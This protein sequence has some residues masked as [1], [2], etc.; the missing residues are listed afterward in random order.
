M[1]HILVAIGEDPL[2]PRLIGTAASLAQSTGAAVT[3]LHVMSEGEYQTLSESQ[4]AGHLGPPSAISQAEERARNIAVAAARD[5]KERG[6]EFTALGLVGD[7]AHSVLAK[8]QQLDVDVIVVGHEHLH[9]L[10][11]LRA[12][13]SVSRAILE[14]AERPVLVVPPIPHS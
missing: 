14:H 3:V 4:V 7:P 10:G 11:R 6:V 2:A 9:G 8:A 5:L 13:G 1:K 12:I